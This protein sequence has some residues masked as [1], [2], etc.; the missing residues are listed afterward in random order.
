M[1]SAVA[2]TEG[3]SNQTEG[4]EPQARSFSFQTSKVTYGGVNGAYY[5]ST[6]SRRTDGDGVSNLSVGRL[7]QSSISSCFNVVIFH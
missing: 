4:T 3:K 6:R 1:T 7:I 5:T 2:L